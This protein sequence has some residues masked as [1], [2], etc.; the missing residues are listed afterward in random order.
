MCIHERWATS[1]AV[2]T[3]GEIV[4]RDRL[5]LRAVGEVGIQIVDFGAELPM[6]SACTIKYSILNRSGPPLAEFENRSQID[7][8]SME[9]SRDYR[10]YRHLK[11]AFCIPSLIADITSFI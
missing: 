8:G 3:E 7:P 9:A 5:I 1:Q 6:T 11:E 2:A 10:A 4:I